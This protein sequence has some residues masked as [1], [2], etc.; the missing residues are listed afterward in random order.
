MNKKYVIYVRTANLKEKGKI[1]HRKQLKQFQKSAKK[2]EYI[3]IKAYHE[4]CSNTITDYTSLQKLVKEVP[5]GKIEAIIP[6]N[7]S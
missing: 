1:S 5:D 2:N 6:S 3:P 4:L 7:H